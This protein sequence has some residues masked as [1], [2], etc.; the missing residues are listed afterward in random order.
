M[1]PLAHEPVCA[2]PAAF[3]DHRQTPAFSVQRQTDPSSVKEIELEAD[4]EEE[5]EEE[6]EEEEK[7]EGVC[8]G[9]D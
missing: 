4:A 5:K 6:E 8:W 9:K 7:E 3:S 1:L 2:G